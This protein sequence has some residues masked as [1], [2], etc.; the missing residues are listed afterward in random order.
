MDASVTQAFVPVRWA[1][2]TLASGIREQDA[3]GDEHPGRLCYDL[4]DRL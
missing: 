4:S 2:Q 1:G 3:R